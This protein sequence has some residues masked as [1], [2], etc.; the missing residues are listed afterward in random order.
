MQTATTIIPDFTQN[1]QSNFYYSFLILPKPKREAIETIYAFCRYTDDI[2][3]E[4]VDVR[5][6]YARLRSWTNE[7]QLSLTGE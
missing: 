6:K 2:V 4:G 1:R 3:D 7:L 5:E